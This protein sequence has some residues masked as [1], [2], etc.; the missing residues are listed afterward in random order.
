MT[1]PDLTGH[2]FGDPEKEEHSIKWIFFWIIII[3]TIGT[4]INGF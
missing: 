2:G 3:L 4:I 1:P